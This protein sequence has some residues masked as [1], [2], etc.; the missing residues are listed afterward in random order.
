MDTADA[1]VAEVGQHLLKHPSCT[2]VFVQQQDLEA[3]PRYP[4]LL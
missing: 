2:T 1:G 4:F 3:K